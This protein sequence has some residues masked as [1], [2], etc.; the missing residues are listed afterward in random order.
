M[1]FGLVKANTNTMVLFGEQC[2]PGLF[3]LMVMDVL[4]MHCKMLGIFFQKCCYGDKYLAERMLNSNN[5]VTQSGVLRPVR[6]LYP[7]FTVSY[8]HLV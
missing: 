6:R 3:I 8:H 2:Q 5:D 1:R 4:L 7:I